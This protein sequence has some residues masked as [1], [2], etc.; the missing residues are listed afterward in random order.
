MAN[1][2][3]RREYESMIIVAMHIVYGLGCAYPKHL[4]QE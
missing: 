3:V 4:R 2:N 1:M